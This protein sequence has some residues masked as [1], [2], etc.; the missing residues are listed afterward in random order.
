M[1]DI[2][3]YADTGLQMPI[4]KHSIGSSV[5]KSRAINTCIALDTRWLTAKIRENSTK[6][7]ALVVKTVGMYSALPMYAHFASQFRR[8]E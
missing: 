5:M 2:V 1:V 4:F 8:L 7:A 6:M 3:Q